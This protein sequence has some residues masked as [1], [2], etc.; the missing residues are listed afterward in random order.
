[1]L[2]SSEVMG[3]TCHWLNHTVGATSSLAANVAVL[4]VPAASLQLVKTQERCSISYYAAD[5]MP[6]CSQSRH[7]SPSHVVEAI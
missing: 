7:H 3:A 1:M 2:D 5:C 4:L 6:Y